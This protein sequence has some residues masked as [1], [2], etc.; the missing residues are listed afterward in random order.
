V[1][2]AVAQNVG[3]GTDTPTTK[4]NV[5]QNAN[6]S[7]IQVELTGNAGNSIT[8]IPTNA[9]NASSTIFVP[10]FSS[11]VGIN[12][13]MINAAS[14]ADGMQLL[15]LGTGAGQ[16]IFHDNIGVGQF[17]DMS[18]AGNGLS[19]Q[20]INHVGNGNGSFVLH[21]GAGN[22]YRVNHSGTGLG[23]LVDHTGAGIGSV[24]IMGQNAISHVNDLLANG[25]TGSL[26]VMDGNDGDGYVFS[27]VDNALAPTT[28]GDGFGFNG[29]VNTQTPTIGTTINGAV[30]AGT[31]WGVGHG[32]ILTHS[33]ATGRGIEVNIE[34][35]ANAEPNYFGVNEGL[36]SAFV[37]Q[38]QNNVIPGTITVADFAYTGTDVSDHIGVTG[39]STPVAG[40]GIGVQGVGNFYGV[41]SLGDMGATGAKP[42]TIDH[43]AD[44]ENKM[45]KHFA[46]ES[47]EVLNMYR[48]VIELDANGEATVELPDYFELININYSY[49]LTA[50]GTPQQPY[51]LQEIQGNTFVVAGAPNTKVSWTV[52]ADR[53]DPYMQQNPEKG[54]DVVD[55]TGDRQG[56]YLTP[57][58]YGQ[59]ASSGMFYNPK[60]EN[61]AT[62]SSS[63]SPSSLGGY[64]PAGNIG[65]ES[66]NKEPIEEPE[67]N[68]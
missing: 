64:T 25:G 37:G 39:A 28:G 40:W 56:K 20:Q 23:V 4:L 61:G 48:G 65:A 30:F 11:G 31:Q 32:M 16:A 44:P 3:I 14:A 59:P 43:P 17:I 7:G 63:P 12:L 21:S 36:G 8:A 66:V 67:I 41:F 34:G 5:L 55:K 19:G 29:V 6:V 35:A 26:T 51:V 15:Q 58:L 47:N 49:Q 68:E 57:E 2:T 1:Q 33:G 18:V 9:A 10:N 13:G 45:L 46:I 27:N 52:Y 38:N 22:G 53:N 42:F 62:K 60:H 54:I 50:I 24:N